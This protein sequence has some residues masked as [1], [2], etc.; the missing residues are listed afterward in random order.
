M[1]IRCLICLACLPGF[2]ALTAAQPTAGKTEL[3]KV[4]LIGESIRVVYALVETWQREMSLR[5]P[6]SDAEER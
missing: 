2:A 4:V 6:Q 3:P 1:L 5:Q